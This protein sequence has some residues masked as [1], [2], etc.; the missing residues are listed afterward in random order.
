VFQ[1]TSRNIGQSRCEATDLKQGAGRSARKANVVEYART[2]DRLVRAV[3]E[4]EEV[5]TNPGTYFQDVERLEDEMFDWDR[6]EGRQGRASILNRP[7]A[8][9]R[10]YSKETLPSGCILYLLMP[11]KTITS[12]KTEAPAAKR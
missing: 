4:R 9:S 12:P 2:G 3:I 8:R 6:S 5:M 10:M 11:E 7:T 1:R